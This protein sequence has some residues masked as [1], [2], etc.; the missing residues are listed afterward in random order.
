MTKTIKL[1]LSLWAVVPIVGCATSQHP[2]SGPTRPDVRSSPGP[3]VGRYLLQSTG[4]ST[5][6]I[7]TTSATV[8]MLERDFK[9]H[10]DMSFR[11]V[12]FHQGDE[13]KD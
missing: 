7:D 13:P 4:N 9:L 11:K 10:G 1:V 12:P 2:S 3:A 8:W 6:I 5:Y